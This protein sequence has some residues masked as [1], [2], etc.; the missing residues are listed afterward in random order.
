MSTI[1]APCGAQRKQN[2]IA[3]V[4]QPAPTP[5]R[6]QFQTPQKFYAKITPDPPHYSPSP[7]VNPFE[8]APA[9]TTPTAFRGPRRAPD[10]SPKAAT[11]QQHRNCAA[12]FAPS[13]FLRSPTPAIEPPIRW[14][15]GRFPGQ[16]QGRLEIADGQ[17][18]VDDCR[19]GRR[20]RF[21]HRLP[22]EQ[23]QHRDR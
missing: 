6:T 20:I 8:P 21:P 3:A 23:V 11:V 16:L 19:R 1:G 5:A 18:D 14:R 7:T 2:E 4:T 22:G 9:D 17:T 13:P 12:S 10:S 15:P